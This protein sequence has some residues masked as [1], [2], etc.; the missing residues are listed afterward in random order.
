[1]TTIQPGLAKVSCDVTDE[2]MYRHLCDAMADDRVHGPSHGTERWFVNPGEIQM[3]FGRGQRSN[4]V[5]ALEVASGGFSSMP[6]ARIL[7]SA[8][9]PIPA[10]STCNSA[11]T[12]SAREAA[13]LV[14][15]GL[16]FGLLPSRGKDFAS[17]ISRL[18]IQSRC[19]GSWCVA[20]VIATLRVTE[21][22]TAALAPGVE[23]LL[24]AISTMGY[25]VEPLKFVGP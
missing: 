7:M 20:V 21:L 18:R 23:A 16:P 14:A 6:F 8:F 22:T 19:I 25:V 1:M 12:D 3:D 10:K 4:V 11:A 5:L 15:E 9:T 13:A 24:C 17:M 2:A